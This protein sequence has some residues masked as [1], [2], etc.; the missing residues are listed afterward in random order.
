MWQLLRRH[1]ERAV[2]VVGDVE[3]LVA[4][5]VDVVDE[6][7]VAAATAFLASSM[8]SGRVL[9]KSAS[10]LFPPLDVGEAGDAIDL[11]VDVVHVLV[12]L[13][14]DVLDALDIGFYVCGHLSFFAMVL[15][16]ICIMRSRL[17]MCGSSSLGG[18]GGTGVII[19][20]IIAIVNH[21][22]EV[23]Q[24]PSGSSRL[25]GVGE[26]CGGLLALLVCTTGVAG[27]SDTG[28]G[29]R[30]CGGVVA[31]GALKRLQ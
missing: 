9:C 24:R 11:V 10:R 17:F 3:V 26:S 7:A 18:G 15:I 28:V 1:I 12:H 14:G 25:V 19:P 31:A 23:E 27:A 30:L 16:I 8:I 20:D 13:V 6:A 2:D 21:Q 22:E 4:L 29:R 5:R